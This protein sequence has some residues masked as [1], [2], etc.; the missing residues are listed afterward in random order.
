MKQQEQHTQMALSPCWYP[1]W[2]IS[3]VKRQM[4][5]SKQKDESF[6]ETNQTAYRAKQDVHGSSEAAIRLYK[7]Y[8]IRDHHSRYEVCW[9]IPRT[10]SDHETSVS[11][12]PCRNCDKTYTGEADLATAGTSAGSF[13]TQR[14]DLHANQQMT[15]KSANHR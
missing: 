8:G 12:K 6:T 14:N 13:T 2:S 5:T 9:H 7:R 11:I 15:S 1:D 10:S 4:S 3:K